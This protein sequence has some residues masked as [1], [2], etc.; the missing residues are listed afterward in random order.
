MK[1]E[2]EFS[3]LFGHNIISNGLY[4]AIRYNVEAKKTTEFVF[5]FHKNLIK[6]VFLWPNMSQKCFKMLKYIC[7]REIYSCFPPFYIWICAKVLNKNFYNIQNM[8][9]RILINYDFS[10]LKSNGVLN[11]SS[12]SQGVELHQTYTN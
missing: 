1:K 6:L 12:H 3:C 9:V 7:E 4:Q 10:T 8:Y 11:N 2:N 5:F